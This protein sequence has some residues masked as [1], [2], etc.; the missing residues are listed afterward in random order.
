M[1]YI[2]YQIG[3]I[4]YE[5]DFLNIKVNWGGLYSDKDTKTVVKSVDYVIILTDS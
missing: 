4:K 5:G 1:G 3:T 2:K